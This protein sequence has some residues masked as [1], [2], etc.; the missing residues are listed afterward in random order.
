MMF[1][2]VSSTPRLT[3]YESFTQSTRTIFNAS[4]EIMIIERQ[5]SKIQRWIFGMIIGSAPFLII[6][7]C[8]MFVSLCI[9][10]LVRFCQHRRNRYR[11]NIRTNGIRSIT[12]KISV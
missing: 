11:Q 4:H 10:N 6:L 8:W 5:Q 9:N 12:S 7:I 1:R 3:S 2:K